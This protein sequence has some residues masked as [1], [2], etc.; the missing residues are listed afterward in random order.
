MIVCGVFDSDLDIINKLIY[1]YF[2]IIYFLRLKVI[3]NIY[4]SYP[5]SF[6][7]QF[8]IFINQK[9]LMI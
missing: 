5:F 9:F 6:N 1:Q 7:N 8:N 2:L 4:K 3:K